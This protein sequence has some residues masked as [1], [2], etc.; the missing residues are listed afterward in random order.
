VNHISPISPFAIVSERLVQLEQMLSQ[1]EK[2]E[3]RPR[4]A[5]TATPLATLELATARQLAG[6][7]GARLDA[8]DIVRDLRRRFD[9]IGFLYDTS[10][11]LIENLPLR[12]VLDLVVDTL[13]HQQYSFVAVLLGE[14]ELG[15]YLY[16]EMRGVVDPLRFQ[17]KQCPL[18]LWGELAHALVRRLDPDE[19]DYLI[20]SD[21]ATMGRP[22][23]EEF[24][25]LERHGSL[26][27]V[28]LRKDHIAMGALLLGRREPNGFDDPE[29]CAELV[30]I[31]GSAAMALYHSQMR[32]ELQERADQLVGLQ[33]FTKSLAADQPLAQLLMATA[34]GVADLLGDVDVYLLVLRRQLPDSIDCDALGYHLRLP[35]EDLCVVSTRDPVADRPPFPAGLYRLVMW[36]IEA[37]QALFF[38]PEKDTALPEDLY[39]NEVGRALLVPVIS[40]DAPIGAI[41]ALASAHDPDFDE[42]D[43][44]V[45]RTMANA[46]AAIIRL[47]TMATQLSPTA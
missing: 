19:P 4:M 44:V 14:T 15:P 41:L 46:A 2:G 21:M 22:K 13:W 43:M 16:Q 11:R 23:P 29:L 31:A 25:W 3:A 1:S 30:E 8:I 32:H 33:L 24:P 26:M 40:G 7:G 18:P 28:P 10:R 17:G 37:S 47:T 6:G 42:S 38:D 34:T 39:Y 35:W 12:E 9:Q 27:I 5:A 45:T 36:T 20:I